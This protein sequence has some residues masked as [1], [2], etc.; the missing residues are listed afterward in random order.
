M[1]VEAQNRIREDALKTPQG[2]VTLPSDWNIS[3]SEFD[4]L[5]EEEMRKHYRKDQ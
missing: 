4:R 1:T 3:Q 5:V 2:H